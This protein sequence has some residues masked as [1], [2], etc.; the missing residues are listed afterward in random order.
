MIVRPETRMRLPT[1]SKTL[2][3][4]WTVTTKALGPRRSLRVAKPARP[5]S[6]PLRRQQDCMLDKG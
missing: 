2:K 1:I 5:L 4:L 6:P 3:L